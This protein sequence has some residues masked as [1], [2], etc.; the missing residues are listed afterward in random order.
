[1]NAIAP[2]LAAAESHAHAV[3]AEAL[4]GAAS[5]VWLIPLFPLLACLVI[6]LITRHHGKLSAGLS[7]AAMAASLATATGVFL[8]RLEHQM[9]SPPMEASVAWISV[10]NKGVGTVEMGLLVDNLSAVMLLMVCF[11]ALLIQSYSFAYID[12]EIHHFPT[13]GSASMA[14][15]YAY[16]S[17]F[18][19]SMLGLVLSNN[20]LQIYIFWELVGLCS[21][22]LIGFWY[23]KKSAADA[24]KKAFIVTKFADLGFLIGILMVAIPS[25][26][27][28]FLELMQPGVLMVGAFTTKAVALVLIF[29]G[30]IGKSA[31]F[32]L[33]I[34]LPDAMEGPTPVSALIHAA[35]MVAA[36]IFLV[37]RL[38]DLYATVEGAALTVAV[39]GT[40]TALLAASIAVTQN[41]I[42][43]VLAYSTVSQLGFMLAALGCGALTAGVF[44]LV[45]HA[46]FKAL[47]F[48]GS[49]AVIVACHNNDMW[50]MG[51]LNKKL[52]KTHFAFAMGCLALAGIP[53]FAGFW[54]KDEVVAGTQGQP[55]IMVGLLLA[56]FLTA[57]YVTRMYCI[58]F[59]GEYRG[60]DQAGQFAGPVPPSDLPT[61]VQPS[62]DVLGVI[63]EWTEEK[64][65]EQKELLPPA[66]LGAQ[67]EK[68]GESPHEPTE[69]SPVMYG[70][71]LILSL[72]AIFLGFA[73]IPGEWNW[74]HH[75]IHSSKAVEAPFSLLLMMVSVAVAVGGVSL[76]WSL[77]AKDPLEGERR[78]RSKLGGAWNFLAQK[79]YMDHL[80]ALLV[81]NTM[82]LG[83][84]LAAWFDDEIIDGG[85]RGI[86]WTTGTLGEKLR[87][88]HSGLVQ[89]YILMVL[90]SILILVGVLS[91]IEPQFFLSVEK[92]FGGSQ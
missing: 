18:A 19:F 67:M 66:C 88:E 47:L 31:Q 60:S 24:C 62:R 6:A 17:L 50:T 57:F 10:W 28:N 86:A 56:A 21:Y 45:T 74:F 5:L 76:G 52:P 20:L 73:G 54:S 40:L 23:F 81:S 49:G 92:I 1:M 87:Y 42:K 65:L 34:W 32:P 16:L 38:F 33:Q 43:R 4:A 58:T 90:A 48:L 61:P 27:F 3:E 75:F 85:V 15:F 83:A 14:R 84:R 51:G 68:G 26:T 11:I 55:L 35:T 41:D 8:Q 82:F 12:T 77:Y 44:H 9:E 36:G 29:C 30:A 89:H 37:A 7:M 64:A 39:I 69:V 70:P 91:F 79:W 63:P 53:P 59:L 72:F 13:Q 80:W 22:F 2:I 46:F 78:L 25:G 71:L